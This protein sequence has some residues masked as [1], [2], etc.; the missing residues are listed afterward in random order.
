MT[1]DQKR[2]VVA[3]MYQHEGGSGQ[4][5]GKSTVNLSPKNATAATNIIENSN[6]WGEAAAALNQKFGAGA[7]TQFDVQLKTQF[8]IPS[9]LQ[10]LSQQ[11]A[12]HG[13]E[14]SKWTLDQWQQNENQFIQ[15]HSYNSD[16]AKKAFDDFFPNPGASENKPSL[17]SNIINWLKS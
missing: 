10:T 12:R 4:L 2:A 8:Q 9:D 15:D 14:P 1:P 5:L 7:A 17:W 16:A 11:A 13:Q 6:S 3:Q